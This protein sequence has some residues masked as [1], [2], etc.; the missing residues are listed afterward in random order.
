LANSVSSNVMCTVTVILLIG[1]RDYLMECLL[2][3]YKT[4]DV[5]Q[6]THETLFIPDVILSSG[7]FWISRIAFLFKSNRFIPPLIDQLV[8]C[9]Y[10]V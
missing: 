1:I 5:L 10:M 2:L 9:V 3:L 4:F 8:A 7:L 6:S